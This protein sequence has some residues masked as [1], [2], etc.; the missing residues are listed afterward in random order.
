MEGNKK[1]KKKGFFQQFSPLVSEDTM[2]GSQELT[3]VRVKQLASNRGRAAGRTRFDIELT[4][5]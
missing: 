1:K 4:V 2:K 5:A 3:G